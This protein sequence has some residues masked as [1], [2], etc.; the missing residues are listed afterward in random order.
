MLIQQIYTR[1]PIPHPAYRNPSKPTIIKEFLLLLLFAVQGGTS[2]QTNIYTITAKL[3][4]FRIEPPCVCASKRAVFIAVESISKIIFFFLM[5][6][7]CGSRLIKNITQHN[8]IH[9]NIHN[10]THTHT[11]SC[12]QFSKL[13]LNICKSSLIPKLDNL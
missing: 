9:I 1:T 4:V 6:W 13:L 3:I 5:Q 12:Y 8:H 7:R 11:T 10:Y 2:I